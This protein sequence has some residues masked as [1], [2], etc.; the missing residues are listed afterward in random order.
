MSAP[1]LA[2]VDAV[3]RRPG[4][5]RVVWL[6]CLLPL[7]GWVV[8]GSTGWAGGLGVNPA[9]TLLRGTGD[10]TLNLLLAGLAL[11]PL[12]RLSSLNGPVRWR[13]TVGL[14][15][16]AYALL[17]ALAYAWLD[18]GLDPTAIVRDL[19]K[20]PF[21]LI[22]FLAFVLLL[23]LALTST[24]RAMRAL[25]GRRWQRLHRLVYLIAPLGLLH[26]AWMRASK[27][28]LAEIAPEVLALLLLLGLRW[29][30]H[31]APRSLD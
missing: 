18:M 29:W 11:T 21:A 23:P 7:L 24:D 9:E 13:R 28:R 22:G 4:A 2:R 12:R 27:G 17:H 14:W 6:L 25:G 19:G 8:R 1:A 26:L 15:A 3:L 20:R 16:F 5:R 10:W 31:P 30:R